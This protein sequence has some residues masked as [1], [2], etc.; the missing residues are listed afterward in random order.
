[1]TVLRMRLPHTSYDIDKIVK[2]RKIWGVQPLKVDKVSNIVKSHISRGNANRNIATMESIADLQYE[3]E[4]PDTHKDGTPVI[5]DR[6]MTVSDYRKH[7]RIGKP[8]A[9]KILFMYDT[10]EQQLERTHL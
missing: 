6:E 7:V 4:I 8:Q 1:M 9:R 2:P 5:T 10:I 3:V